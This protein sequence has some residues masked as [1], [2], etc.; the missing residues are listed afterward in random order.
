MRWNSKLY[1]DTHHFVSEYGS[2][3]IELLNP[4]EGQTVLDI[5]CGTGDLAYEMTQE[6]CLVTGI[7]ASAEMVA[8]ARKKFP[9]IEF[10]QMD[11][12]DFE[13][14]RIF[15][16]IFT[17][18]TFHW[19]HKEDHPKVLAQIKK[20]L[21]PNGRFIAEF[22]EANNV[23]KIRKALQTVLRK[24]GHIQLA[25]AANRTWYFPD[26]ETYHKLLKRK[27]FKIEYMEG[28]DRPTPLSGGY[29]GL[30]NWLIMFGHH[31]FEG[32]DQATRDSLITKVEE[33]LEPELFHNGEWMADYVRL[34]FIAQH[35]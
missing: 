32:L 31:W 2:N 5:G 18:A 35:D 4:Q 23:F 28:F 14:N 26:M 27:G 24:K 20:H 10:L 22:G 25:N 33:L 6:G 9:D 11:A 30:R 12:T 15:D 29:N 19:I 16:S 3:L 21:K 13:L 17:N 1:D 34:R 8:A 7:D